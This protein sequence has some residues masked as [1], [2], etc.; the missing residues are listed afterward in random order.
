MR[1]ALVG[2]LYQS[3]NHDP[4]PRL[5]LRIRHPSLCAWEVQDEVLKLRTEAGGMIDDLSLSGVTLGAL[6][7]QIEGLGCSVEYV[8]SELLGF[9]AEV[10]IEGAGRESNNNGDHIHAFDSLLWSLMSAYARQM[11]DLEYSANEARRQ[12]Y[13]DSVGGSWLDF[14][15]ARFGLLRDG[16]TD[17][18]Y[19]DWIVSEVTRP[20]T[21]PFAIE[22]A[23]LAKTG[24]SI[25]I[26]EPWK[27]M[28]RPDVSTLS[29]VDHLQDGH[30]YTY[31]VIQP[32]ASRGVDWP[33][34]LPVI[35]N[36]RPAGVY[37]APP[38]V[39]IPTTEI[40]IPISVDYTVDYGCLS[41]TGISA[42]AD[43]TQVLD[44]MRLSDYEIQYNL[45][46]CAEQVISVANADSLEN[47]QQRIN[48]RTIAD[49][50][51][52]LSDG[53]V[54]GDENATL[55]C[56]A[57]HFEVEPALILSDSAVPSDYVS[58][59]VVQRVSHVTLSEPV[60]A[61]LVADPEIVQ[62]GSDTTYPVFADCQN[63]NAWTGTWGARNWLG[64]HEVGVASETLPA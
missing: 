4:R 50:S 45:P 27:R 16:R 3:L 33:S 54:L 31:H 6:C 52:C 40:V 56:G 38:S 51:V 15:G 39:E 9:G 47:N 12:V 44:L 24:Q 62:S 5:A 2:H 21:T 60:I 22:A 8:N 14:W 34:V 43:S 10:L 55:G 59:M 58:G 13:L 26:D 17:A 25:I 32:K 42:R 37:V 57:Q 48:T 35:E 7:E 46:F 20:R 1:D 28:F 19:R 63:Q 41:Q 30:Y 36:N 11:L 64:W 23:V 61:V 53:F 29:G 18:E 49:A